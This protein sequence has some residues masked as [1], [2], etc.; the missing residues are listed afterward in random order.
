L[1]FNDSLSS[2]QCRGSFFQHDFKTSQAYVRRGVPLLLALN[3]W[4]LIA[5]LGFTLTSTTRPALSAGFWTGEL[6][7]YAPLLSI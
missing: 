5:R 3:V 1:I 6:S 4:E 2:F 7:L